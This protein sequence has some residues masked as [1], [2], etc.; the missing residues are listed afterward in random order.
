MK[1]NQSAMKMDINER[2]SCTGNFRHINIRYFVIKDQVYKG[3][4]I[5]MYCPSYLMFTYNFT[6]P[7]QVALFHKFW[8]IMMATV[9]PYTLMK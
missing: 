8:D 4:I 5:V 2:N 6:K 9:V 7:V 3:N 1:Y